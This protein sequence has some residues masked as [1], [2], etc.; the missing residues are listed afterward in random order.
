MGWLVYLAQT[1]A[2]GEGDMSNAD[3]FSLVSMM[4]V[5]R[6]VDTHTAVWSAVVFAAISFIQRYV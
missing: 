4:F 1:D 6:A 5:A 3:W 2:E